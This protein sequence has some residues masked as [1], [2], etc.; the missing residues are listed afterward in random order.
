MSRPLLLSLVLTLSG[1]GDIV[2]GV[3][4]SKALV[5][6]KVVGA[7]DQPLAGVSVQVLKSTY[8][9]TSGPDGSYS[10]PFAPGTFQ[11]S[12][13]LDGYTSYQLDLD[14][15]QA[16]T[17]PAEQVKLY[18]V[19]E[20]RGIYH[21]GRSGLQAIESAKVDR[22][23]IQSGW[24]GSRSKYFCTGEGSSPIT[25]SQARFVD[26]S[27]A[28]LR[29]ARLG[30]YGLVYYPKGSGEDDKGYNGFMDDDSEMAGLEALLVRSFSP[31]P[32]QYAWVTVKRNSN[33]DARV[34]YEEPCFPF[35]IV[36]G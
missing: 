10:V 19:P 7:Y 4:G 26:T 30:D 11:L 16:T 24:T 20:D 17:F 6:G 14:I 3:V 12:Y 9:A 23:V 5:E 13:N 28:E 27:A 18:P 33:G 22:Q 35:K 21:L 36:P 2:N 31:E 25:A 29:L 34:D 1:C 32:G 8:K 15:Q